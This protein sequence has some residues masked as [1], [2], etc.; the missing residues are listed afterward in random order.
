M[1]KKSVSILLLLLSFFFFL[2]TQI[3]H[4]TIE[5]RPTSYYR[6]IALQQ[7]LEA[8]MK[9]A[10]Q[11]QYPSRAYTI[12]ATEQICVVDLQHVDTNHVLCQ[13]K[14]ICTAW[15][16]KEANIFFLPSHDSILISDLLPNKA[17]ECFSMVDG[18][19]F[20]TIKENKEKNGKFFIEMP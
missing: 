18:K 4:T 17:I 5:Q 2:S 3:I 6:T 9:A 19:F 1:K 15:Q 8:Q 11:G 12:P 20:F 16:R 14:E 7:T 10:A 13:I